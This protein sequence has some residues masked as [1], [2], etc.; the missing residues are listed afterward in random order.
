MKTN[1]KMMQN[2]I[3]NDKIKDK[4][5]AK[6]NKNKNKN[7]KKTFNSSQLHRAIQVILSSKS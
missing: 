6:K 4:V 3:N 5:K 7:K 1:N 2:T